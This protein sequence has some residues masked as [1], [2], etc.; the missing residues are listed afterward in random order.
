MILNQLGYKILK[1]LYKTIRRHFLCRYDNNVYVDKTY[2][3]VNMGPIFDN[4]TYICIQ[5]QNEG[6]LV[7]VIY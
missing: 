6:I 3:R 5:I 2:D 4:A 7:S 1:S